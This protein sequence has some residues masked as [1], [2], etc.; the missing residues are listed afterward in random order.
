M[1]LPRVVILALVLALTATGSASAAGVRL[2]SRDENLGAA[3]ALADGGR[4]L[5]ARTAPLRF[6]LVGVHWRGSG[7]IWFRTASGIGPWSAWREARPEAEDGPDPTS[8]EAKARAGW[9]IGNPYW[10]GPAERIQYRV[11]GRIVRL[12]AHFVSSTPRAAPLQVALAGTPR[13]I[14]RAGWGA[15]ES[16]V[17]ASPSYADRLAFA[18]VH[19]TAGSSPST[20]AESAAIVRAIQRYHVLS[21]G[22]N[23][24][25]YNFLVDRFGQV[26]EGRRGGIGRNVIGAH[27]Q[28]FNT[29][30]AGIAVIG[31]YG[32]TPISPEAEE[33]LVSLLA[34]RLDVGHV[35]PAS[36]L[37]WTSLGSP[38][39]SSGTRVWLDAVSGHRDVGLTSCPGSLLYRELGDI[40]GKAAA[41][42]LPKIYSPRVAGS[43]GGPI[44]FTARLSTSADWTV[45]VSDAL[46]G[47]VASGHGTGGAVDWTWDATAVTPARYSYAI[48]ATGGF[49]PARGQVGSFVPLELTGLRALPLAATPNGDGVGDATVVTVTVSVPASVRAWLED[50]TNT[51]VAPVIAMRS[52]PAGATRVRWN[53]AAV[54]DGRYRIVAEA[55]SG[56]E[57][58]TRMTSVVVDRTLGSLAVF[59]GVFSP[60]GDG[61]IETTALGFDL[62]READAIV[63]V[64]TGTKTVAALFS[65]HV[66]EPGQQT[67]AWDGRRAPDGRYRAV[68][69]ATTS[70]GTRGLT[71]DLVVD[72]VRPSVSYLSAVRYRGGTLARFVVSERA[73]VVLSIGGTVVRV[74]RDAGVARAW[75]PVPGRYVRVVA[76]DT[77]G[78]VSRAAWAP[79]RAA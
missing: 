3:R 14:S 18:V 30:S 2:V 49:R 31:S 71:K 8:K 44:R 39:Y 5:P 77:A 34:W 1:T 13:I 48:E 36:R 78:N 23:D 27:A 35:D 51:R 60:N 47:T 24:I 56:T 46:G 4:V 26:F 41:T 12:R 68:V 64:A 19:H 57:Q 70:L 11:A 76:W 20:P 50:S 73:R 58:V 29:G 79:V 75:I 45:T 9:K 25:G 42:G 7:R 63:R 15:N 33:A 16:I 53:P 40:A 66:T 37:A 55:T 67:F 43:L 17:R 62:T 74:A 69:T 6:N 38:K 65:G 61:R 32:S 54:A 21:N 59:P 28:G 10:T 22:W 52:V 72:T